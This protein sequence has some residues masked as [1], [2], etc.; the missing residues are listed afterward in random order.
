MSGVW[1]ECGLVSLALLVSCFGGRLRLLWASADAEAAE[2]RCLRGLFWLSFSR[3]AERSSLG[4]CI[5]H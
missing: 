2:G 5:P 4:V 3:R 1:G